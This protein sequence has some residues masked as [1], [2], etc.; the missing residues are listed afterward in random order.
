M[1]VIRAE[2]NETVVVWI[3]DAADEKVSIKRD[4]PESQIGMEGISCFTC[5]VKSSGLEMSKRL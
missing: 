1:C 5:S 4:K 2:K 3:K